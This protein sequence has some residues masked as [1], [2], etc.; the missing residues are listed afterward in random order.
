[1]PPTR[2]RARQQNKMS[3]DKMERISLIDQQMSDSEGDYVFY[4]CIKSH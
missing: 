4:F 3:N 1:M 2:A